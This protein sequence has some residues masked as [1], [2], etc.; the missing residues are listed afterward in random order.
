MMGRAEKDDEVDQET[1]PPSHTVTSNSSSRFKEQGKGFYKEH[2][3]LILVTLAIL[4]AKAYPEGGAIYLA[5]HVT[6]NWIAVMITFREYRCGI[7]V[8]P[9]HC[10][11]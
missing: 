10:T 9:S 7:G 3:F 6:S 11:F 5:P 8:G 2:E 1:Q 4:L